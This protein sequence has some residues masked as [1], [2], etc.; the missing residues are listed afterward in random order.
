[1]KRRPDSEQFIGKITRPLSAIYTISKAVDFSA[2]RRSVSERSIADLG[3]VLHAGSPHLQISIVTN[4][5]AS[6][7]DVDDK[8]YEDA[9]ETT[10]C[11]AVVVPSIQEAIVPMNS[12]SRNSDCK[13]GIVFEESS[14]HF[15]PHNHFNKE[16]PLRVSSIYQAL[17]KAGIQHRCALF[18]QCLSLPS[19]SPE[20]AFL[21]DEDFLRVHLP[22]YMQRLN[23]LSGCTCH[24]TLDAEA[25][26]FQSIFL[27]PD[28]VRQAKSAAASL[29]R[30][31]SRVVQGEIDNGFAVIRPPGHHAERGMASGYCIVNNIAVAAA[32]AKDYLGVGKVLIVDWDVHHGNGTQSA[33]LKDPNVLYCSVHRWQGGNFFPFLKGAGPTTVGIGEGVGFNVNVGWSRKGMGD[34][35]YY[36]AWDHIVMPLAREFKPDLV[37]V[38]AGFD[39][40][41]GDM[42]ECH[43][44]PECFGLL[45]QSLMTVA[46]GKVVCSL[47]GGYFRSVLG[48][49]VVNVVEALLSRQCEYK[50]TIVDLKDINATAAKNIRATISAHK[51]YWSCFQ[52]E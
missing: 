16:Q 20:S 52:E 39:A 50:E 24:K 28:S 48:E 36:A 25:Q 14:L 11:H 29:C 4:E 42:G 31:V 33:F 15:D 26:Q 35:E 47:E 22:A 46:N 1:M 40:A 51:P 21:N 9:T 17:V 5:S 10:P 8:H 41:D 30:L 7:S 37:L 49:C 3:T 38:S 32:Y 27:T 45:T 18:D 23:K 13:T 43:V 12:P 6:L 2:L 44:T 19:H 34:A